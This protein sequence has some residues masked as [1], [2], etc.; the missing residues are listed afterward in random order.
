MNRRWLRGI[1]N[2]NNSLKNMIKLQKNVK[3]FMIK[4]LEK[5]KEKNQKK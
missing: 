2:I 5:N 1:T 3:E 4:L